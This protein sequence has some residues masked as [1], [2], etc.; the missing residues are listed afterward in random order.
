[1]ILAWIDKVRD[2]FYGM[3]GVY[4]EEIEVKPET[5]SCGWM[6]FNSCKNDSEGLGN[7]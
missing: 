1:M 5:L 4:L 6:A 7:S 3:G 2:Y